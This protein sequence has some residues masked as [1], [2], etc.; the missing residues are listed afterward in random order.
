[1]K[2][3]YKKLQSISDLVYDHSFHRP[4]SQ[5]RLPESDKGNFRAIAKFFGQES[6]GKN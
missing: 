2:S 3:H 4:T 6:A 1:M 5:G